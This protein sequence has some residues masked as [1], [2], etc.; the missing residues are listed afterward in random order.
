MVFAPRGGLFRQERH[1]VSIPLSDRDGLRL[2]PWKS[3][4][5]R[6]VHTPFLRTSC[7]RTRAASCPSPP[8]RPDPTPPAP[9]RQRLRT[10]ATP[11]GAS[12]RPSTPGK[13]AFPHCR[14]PAFRRLLPCGRSSPVP[15]R[16][17]SILAHPT[18]NVLAPDPRNLRP[19]ETPLTPERGFLPPTESALTLLRIFL[20]LTESA[21]TVARTILP[22]T[23][24]ALTVGPT[25][26]PHAVSVLS[27][28]RPPS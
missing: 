14:S 22:P 25:S 3:L 23:E 10:L 16:T 4:Q 15:N 17:D 18:D 6:H 5:N 27:V 26:V 2:F 21:L 28:A 7:Q 8:G 19:T 12:R 9:R 20:R 11:P 1:P 24:S 13:Q